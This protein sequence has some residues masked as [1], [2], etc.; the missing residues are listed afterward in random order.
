MS[1]Q[2]LRILP[3]SSQPLA[4]V[5]GVAGTRGLGNLQPPAQ[6]G[7]TVERTRSWLK[8]SRLASVVRGDSVN[9]HRVR[10][11]KDMPGRSI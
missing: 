10:F 5:Q 3:R 11:E 1:L 6:V 7:K 8:L 4:T 2:Q 9:P